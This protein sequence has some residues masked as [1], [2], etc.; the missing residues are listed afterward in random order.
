MVFAI[1][2]QGNRVSRVWLR[3]QEVAALAADGRFDYLVVESTGIS[4]PLPVAITFSA[5]DSAGGGLADVARLDTMVS[6][7]TFGW[8]RSS[9]TCPCDCNRYSL[10]LTP[11]W[12]KWW[13][14]CYFPAYSGHKKSG[15]RAGQGI[16]T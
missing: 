3:L 10:A 12:S 2:V 7:M 8:S 9:S 11:Q 5:S 6:Q 14:I 13:C 16:N 15:M 4:E 1:T